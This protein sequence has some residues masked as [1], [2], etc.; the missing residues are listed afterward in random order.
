MRKK[1]SHITILGDGGWGTTLAIHLHKKGYKI[2]LWSPFAEYASFLAKRRENI[3]FLPGFK[4]PRQIACISGIQQAIEKSDL[5]VLAIPSK[6]IANIIKL[7]KSFDLSHT[8]VVS[9]VKGIDTASLRRISEIIVKELRNPPLAVLSGPT[10]AREVASGIPASAVIASKDTKLAKNLQKVFYSTNFRIYTNNDIIGV[11]VGGSTKNIIAIAC[12]ICDGMGFG[13]NTKAA[14]LTRGLA[15]MTRLGV[16]MG[17]KASTFAGLSGLGD[18]VTTCFSPES[19]NR[20]LGEQLGKGKRIKVILKKMAMVAEG[21]TTVKAV[22]KLSQ[23]YHVSMPITHEVYRII[24]HGK[25]P[26]NAV[27]DLMERKLKKE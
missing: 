9:V 25:N 7:L 11:E 10:I 1:F 12:G 26:A 24:Y 23:K 6:Y 18:L 14:L 16:A 13:S 4:I 27:K 17:A 20:S 19:R 15:E 8:P 22:E 21:V 3:K 5:I 2:N